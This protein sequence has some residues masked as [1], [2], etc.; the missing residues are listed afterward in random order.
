MKGLI[1][2]PIPQL[3]A[4]DT[5]LPIVSVIQKDNFPFH[6]PMDFHCFIP[7]LEA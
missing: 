2:I 3:S 7:I 4:V 6:Q 1:L 5:S